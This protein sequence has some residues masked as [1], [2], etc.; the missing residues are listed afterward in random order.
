MSLLRRAIALVV[1]LGSAYLAIQMRS[2]SSGL[3][4]ILLIPAVLVA[5][6]A[7]VLVLFDLPVLGDRSFEGS[8]FERTVL[9][10]AAANETN[11]WQPK[12]TPSPK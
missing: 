10:P 12:H 6:F 11:G 7:L 4:G 5:F 2:D 9:S 3:G 8:G 1:F